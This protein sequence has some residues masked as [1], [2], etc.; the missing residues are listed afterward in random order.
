MPDFPIVDAHVHLYDPARISYPWMRD[1]PALDAA[2]LPERFFAE[3]GK[4]EVEALVFVEVNAAAGEHLAEACFVDSAAATE[5]R[6]QAIVACLP[7]GQTASISPDLEALAAMPRV[8]GVRTLI[9]TH[10]DEPG[11]ALQPHF[12]QNVRAVADYDLSFD[13]CLYHPQLRDVI[14]L[15]RQCPAV[16]FVLDHIGKPGIRDGLLQPWMSELKILADEPNVCCKISGVVTEA[17][18]AHWTEAQ[19]TP[20]I[21]HAI[22]CFG[23]ERTM[24]GGDWPVSTLA[25]S[26]QRWVDVVDQVLKGASE[27]ERRQLY[28]DTATAFYQLDSPSAAV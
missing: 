7:L 4:V 26:Y 18:H 14:T 17:D 10:L 9:Q 15:V 5:P 2:H 3:H 8:K 19:V 28:R 27:A 20:Y 11:W 13:L 1:V 24:F 21:D 16:R 6:I 22:E 12:V 25:T 23:F